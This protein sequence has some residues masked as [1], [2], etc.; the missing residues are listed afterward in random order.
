MEGTRGEE[1]TERADRDERAGKRRESLSL[2]TE[3]KH[4]GTDGG[5]K[6]RASQGQSFVGPPRACSG[7]NN[8]VFEVSETTDSLRFPLSLVSL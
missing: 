5:E 7:S 6:K 2:K 4:M 8:N 1:R 3:R